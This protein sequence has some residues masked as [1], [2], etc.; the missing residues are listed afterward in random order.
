MLTDYFGGDN[1]ESKASSG[2]SKNTE[3]APETMPGNC[4]CSLGR[5]PNMAGRRDI[6]GGFGLPMMDACKV[7]AEKHSSV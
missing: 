6:G 2:D 5:V 3:A 1:P 4:T 7:K